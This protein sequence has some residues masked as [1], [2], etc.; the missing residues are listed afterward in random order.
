MNLDR[1]PPSINVPKLR[2]SLRITRVRIHM[3]NASADDAVILD[4]KPEDLLDPS[5]I[6]L[7][8]HDA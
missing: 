7:E 6:D 3:N 1:H 5:V 8:R 4:L 2:P